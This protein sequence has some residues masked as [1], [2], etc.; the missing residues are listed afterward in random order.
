M[1]CRMGRFDS[2]L[3]F[4]VGA[5][6]VLGIGAPEAS[7][8]AQPIVI[9]KAKS[10]RYGIE[11]KILDYDSSKNTVK[12]EIKA[13]KVSG[14]FGTGGVAGKKPPKKLGLKRGQERD[15]QVQPEGS[16]LRRTVIKA[17]DGSGLDTT[18]TRAG[19]EKA[20]AMIPSDRAVVISFEQNDKAA[21]GNGAP[22]F[23]IKMIQIRLTEEELRERFE[24]ISV[25]E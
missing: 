3:L 8:A 11:G 15:F 18:G 7:R 14:G 21:V 2:G 16:V 13:T 22:D 6:L 9:A 10:T 17:M 12:V 25:E 1:V 19:F 24:A 23:R 20:L 4:A 5:A